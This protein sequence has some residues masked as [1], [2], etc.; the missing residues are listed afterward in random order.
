MQKVYN[1]LGFNKAYNFA[2]WIIF[3]GAMFACKLPSSTPPEI[4][5]AN[6]FQSA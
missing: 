5:T 1:P 3:G 6:D 4:L 2:L